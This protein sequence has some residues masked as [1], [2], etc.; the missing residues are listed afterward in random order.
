MV[1]MREE[2]ITDLDPETEGMTT[3][4]KPEPTEMT[5]IVMKRKPTENTSLG[6][7]AKMNEKVI[8]LDLPVGTLQNTEMK[9]ETETRVETGVEITLVEITHNDVE[10]KEGVETLT[11]GTPTV[12]RIPEA[13]IPLEKDT[14]QEEDRTINT[15][16]TAPSQKAL[17]MR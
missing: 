10:M 9:A 15:E 17:L 3:G 2:A 1:V 8:E 4:M 7:G 5:E 12:A 16:E 13:E 11:E 6:K 14:I